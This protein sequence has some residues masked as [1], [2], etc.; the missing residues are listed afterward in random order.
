MP[1]Q[2]VPG[3]G[4]KM[5]VVVWNVSLRERYKIHDARRLS[6]FRGRVTIWHGVCS[7]GKCELGVPTNRIG[8]RLMIVQCCVCKKTR[9]NGKWA[10][11]DAPIMDE[12]SVSHGYCPECAAQ[13]FAQLA[14][15]APKRAKKTAKN[16]SNAA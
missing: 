2:F 16:S 7:L 13:A 15:S 10:Y 11:P 14:A 8:K 12:H 1:W 6:G 9:D 4:Y 3:K 5:T